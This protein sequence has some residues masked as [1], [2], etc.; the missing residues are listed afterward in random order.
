M[1]S[2]RVY[3]APVSFQRITWQ[4]TATVQ[5]GSAGQAVSK[6][7]VRRV[8][9]LMTNQKEKGAKLEHIPCDLPRSS[10]DG[11][12]ATFFGRSVAVPVLPMLSANLSGTRG[13]SD[14]AGLP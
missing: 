13:H 14:S 2:F 5:Q 7:S 9:D 11:I 3:A 4:V 10:P 6:L 1:T 8:Q 12:A